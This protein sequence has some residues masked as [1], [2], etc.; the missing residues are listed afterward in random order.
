[1]KFKGIENDLSIL[2]ISHSTYSDL[3]PIFFTEFR[4]KFTNPCNLFL[5]VDKLPKDKIVD[6]IFVIEE[7]IPEN[8]TWSN[9]VLNACKE[10]QTKYVLLLIDDVFF[11]EKV[12]LVKL[13][14]FL[15]CMKNLGLKSLKLFYEANFK[16][17]LLIP[18]T[19]K[20]GIFNFGVVNRINTHATIWETSFL[21]EILEPSESIWEFEVNG[22]FRSNA[23]FYIGG[24][25]STFFK[26]D[27]GIVKG[28]WERKIYNRLKK[29][30]Y[31]DF[32]D[33][34]KKLSRKETLKRFIILT[35]FNFFIYKLSTDLRKRIK[36]MVMK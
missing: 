13:E 4:K 25:T 16:P 31:A 23:T 2:V 26:Y 17:E 3:W 22:T 18:G 20:L 33:K 11:T 1:M 9:R 27:L 5:S 24:V 15:T 21:Q 30:G 19:E 12:D 7:K 35:V 29:D 34:R 10:I 28:S 8:S 36:K 14:E 6:N 32:L